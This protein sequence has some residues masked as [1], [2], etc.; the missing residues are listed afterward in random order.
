MDVDSPLAPPAAQHAFKAD[1]AY[2][3]AAAAAEAIDE[4]PATSQDFPN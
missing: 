3:S 2:V 4:K 1:A